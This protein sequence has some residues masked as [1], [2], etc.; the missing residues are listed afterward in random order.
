VR[1]RRSL[2]GNVLTEDEVRGQSETISAVV[3]VLA[4]AGVELEA[5]A[6]RAVAVAFQNRALASR[7]H[8]MSGCVGSLGLITASIVKGCCQL[9]DQ[10]VFERRAGYLLRRT[11]DLNVACEPVLIH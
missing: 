1:C 4:K 5:L 7:G 6:M 11:F 3:N 10:A 8:V 9:L 2:I